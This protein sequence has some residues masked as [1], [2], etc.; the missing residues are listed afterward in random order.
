MQDGITGEHRPLRKSSDDR[1]LVVD[2]EL[3]G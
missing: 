3:P 2:L 1:L